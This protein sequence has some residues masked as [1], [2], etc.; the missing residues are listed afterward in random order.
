MRRASFKLGMMSLL[1]AGLVLTVASTAQARGPGAGT[2]GVGVGPGSGFGSGGT[3]GTTGMGNTNAT[4][5]RGNTNATTGTARIGVIGARSVRGGGAVAPQ[6]YGFS[7]IGQSSGQPGNSQ[8]GVQGAAIPPVSG[9]FGEY[10]PPSQY[11]PGN[12]GSY[13][14]PRN[15]MQNAYGWGSQQS[16]TNGPFGNAAPRGWKDYGIFNGRIPND[17]PSAY[18]GGYGSST[19]NGYGSSMNRG[20]GLQGYQSGYQGYWNGNPRP[21]LGYNQSTYGFSQGPTGYIS[22]NYVN[23]PTM[24]GY[25]NPGQ[26]PSANTIGR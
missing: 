23:R 25:G 11:V 12:T 26:A 16:P 15:L 22:G 13:G 21:G 3:T 6:A 5:G 9:V 8:F 4:T 20:Y 1:S 24:I 18:S 2:G 17:R 7:T 10:G 19:A 14:A